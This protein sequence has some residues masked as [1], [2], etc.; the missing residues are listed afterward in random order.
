[1]RRRLSVLLGV[2]L[3]AL[4]MAA[5]SD[6]LPQSSFNSAGDVA[7]E[8]KDLLIP[9]I[10]IAAVIFV[11]VE[12]AL[13]WFLIKYRH[14]EG[15]EPL[16]VHGNTRLEIAWT[17]A[18]ALVL[19]I[20]TV[21]TVSLIYQLSKAPT[22]KSMTVYAV[23]HQW[24]WEFDYPDLGIKTANEL[25]IPVGTD[26][27]VKLCS[28]GD[29]NSGT[30]VG[31]PCTDP[32]PAIGDAVVHSFWVPRLA[33]KQD[34]VPGRTNTM[35]IQA[36]E[37][38]VYPGQC[39][40]FCGL[41]HA[42]MRFEVIAQTPTDFQT[43]VTNQQAEAPTPIAGSAADGGLEVFKTA[44]C[45]GCHTIGGVSEG[46][47]G[48]DLTHFGTRGCFAG[49]MLRVTEEDLSRWLHDPASVK[50]GSFMPNLNLTDEQVASLVAYLES[51][52]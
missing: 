20:I 17:I 18:P 7:R 29:T 1:M 34:V 35:A 38:G 22:G 8:Q 4:V 32:A 30:P 47:G 2:V 46:I 41:S 49:C 48:P 52:K 36:N 37:P 21:P 3:G 33:G 5:C 16:Q 11:L 9:I 6:S 50:P 10:A 31:A 27:F 40:E 12:G 19:A 24:W 42:F 14:R 26:V 23:G 43:W 25:Y 44:G 13:V 39:A 15:S 51:L 28:A 45:I